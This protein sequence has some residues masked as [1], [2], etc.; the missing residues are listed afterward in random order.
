LSRPRP[1]FY[2]FVLEAP[3]SRGQDF[4]LVDYITGTRTASAHQEST[5]IAASSRLVDVDATRR[6]CQK[7]TDGRTNGQTPGIEFG[8]F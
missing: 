5:T 3:E 4:G 8:A 1:I 7:Q 2:Y 6:P